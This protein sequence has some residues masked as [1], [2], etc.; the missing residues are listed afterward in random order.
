MPGIEINNLNRKK[1]S[2]NP[3]DQPQQTN[4][5]SYKVSLFLKNNPLAFT[6]KEQIVSFHQT[7]ITSLLLKISTNPQTCKSYYFITRFII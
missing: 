1:N 6:I 4:N 2:P 7:R 3:E 5:N